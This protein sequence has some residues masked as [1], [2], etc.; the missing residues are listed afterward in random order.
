MLLVVDS[1]R[2]LCWFCSIVFVVDGVVFG[3]G[4]LLMVLLV[5]VVVLLMVSGVGVSFVGELVCDVAGGAV[6]GGVADACCCGCWRWCCRV[7]G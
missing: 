4:V 5:V 1:C 6:A 3:G 7:L 2:R